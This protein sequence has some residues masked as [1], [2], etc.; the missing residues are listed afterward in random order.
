MLRAVVFLLF[1]LVGTA[2]LYLLLNYHFLAAVQLSV[3]VGGILALFI[4]AILL[5]A[6]SYKPEPHDRNRVV[7]GLLTAVVGI[8]VTSFVLMKHKFL[9]GDNPTI[10][11]DSE[12]DMKVIGHALVGSEK[13]Q[14]LLPFEIMSILLLVCVIAGVIIARKR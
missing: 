13:Y 14:Y 9:Y 12:I 1:V 7:G 6:K 11:G 10:L 3:Y 5:T 4:F 2:G 8:A